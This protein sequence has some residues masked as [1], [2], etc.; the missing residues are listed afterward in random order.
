[1]RIKKTH[2]KTR[3]QGGPIL[4]PEEIK[5]KVMKVFFVNCAPFTGLI[6][7]IVMAHDKIS[8]LV[9]HGDHRR[10]R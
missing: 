10:S 6:K 3:N 9:R 7:G 4:L 2:L 8:L 5:V 1:M